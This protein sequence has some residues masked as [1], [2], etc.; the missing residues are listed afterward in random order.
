MAKKKKTK[1]E[2][3]REL[4]A[5]DPKISYSDAAAALSRKGIDLSSGAFYSTRHSAMQ[6]GLIPQI[7]KRRSRRKHEEPEES[8]FEIDVRT[9]L[10]MLEQQNAKLKAV[11]AAL[12]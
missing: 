4:L 12:L 11:I 8:N 9:Q 1:A 7:K 10:A 2:H 5:K 6:K 3:V